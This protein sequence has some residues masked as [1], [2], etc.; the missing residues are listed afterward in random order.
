VASFDH[1]NI[2]LG[3][4]KKNDQKIALFAPIDQTLCSE[5]G[6]DEAASRRREGGQQSRHGG[7]GRYWYRYKY[8]YIQKRKS[9]IRIRR[10]RVRGKG[11]GLAAAMGSHMSRKASRIMDQPADWS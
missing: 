4:K 7:G 11:R 3:E 2:W 8:W 9:L 5:D 6:E 10:G 1:A